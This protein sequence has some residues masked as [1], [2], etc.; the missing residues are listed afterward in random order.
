MWQINDIN[1]KSPTFPPL[2]QPEMI[3]D[4]MFC[5]ADTL[6]EENCSMNF[7]ACTHALQAKM[8]SLVELVLVDR[9]SY[10]EL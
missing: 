10:K 8:N 4:G 2:T 9:G 1:F 3:K 5:N 6:K 7:C